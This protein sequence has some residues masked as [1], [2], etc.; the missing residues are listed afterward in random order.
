[1]AYVDISLI[2][3]VNESNK[4]LKNFKNGNVFFLSLFCIYQSDSKNSEF[5][6]RLETQ[7]NFK[8][9]AV[10]FEHMSKVEEINVDLLKEDLSGL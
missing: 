8:E 6:M 3:Y 10:I 9:W 5:G 4:G 7:D 1:V 2:T